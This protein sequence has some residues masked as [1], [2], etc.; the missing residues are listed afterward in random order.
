MSSGLE[1]QRKELPML[2]TVA[3]ATAFAATQ[4]LFTAASVAESEFATPGEAKTLLEKVVVA[5]KQD[6]AKALEMFASGEGG[7]RVKDLYV[8]CANASDGILTVHLTNEGKELRDTRRSVR[9]NDH[10]ECRRRHHKGDDLLVAAPRHGGAPRED[11]LLHQD[12]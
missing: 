2:R 4:V 12:R 10:G 6:E 8:W 3:L 1:R 11:H 7:F 5:M 9:R